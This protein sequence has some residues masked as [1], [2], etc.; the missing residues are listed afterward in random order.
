MFL[1]L[2]FVLILFN[3]L[4]ISF[5]LKLE[6]PE[7]DE[8]IDAIQTIIDQM[9]K[10]H[11]TINFISAFKDDEAGKFLD[12]KEELLI[13]CKLTHSI[14]LDNYTKIVNS[15]LRIKKNSIFLL[16]TIERFRILLKNIVPTKF[17]FNGNFLFVLIAG[18]M[19]EIQEIFAK[20]WL[21][22]IYNVNV[23]YAATNETVLVTFLP[24]E[25]SE[26]CGSTKPKAINIFRDGEFES[27]M[28]FPA[29]MNNFNGCPLRV[30]TFEDE[31]VVMRISDDEYRGYCIDLLM[32][33]AKQLNFRPDINFLTQE[34]AY[35]IVYD[36][37]TATG[38]LGEVFYNR[39][40]IALGDFFLK[41]NRIPKFD[42]T[43]AYQVM[44]LVWIIPPGLRYTPLQKLMLP[45]EFP[46]WIYLMIT[47]TIGIIV[48]IFINI[49]IPQMRAFVYGVNVKHPFLN[50]AVV[51]L[52]SQQHRMPKRN[53]ARFLI[54]NFMLFTLV[55]RSIYQGSLYRFLQS[56]GRQ[57][58][59]QS[60][61]EML[62]NDFTF[63]AFEASTLDLIKGSSL[64]IFNKTKVYKKENF[65]LHTELNGDEKIAGL[66]T[67]KNVVNANQGNTTI[68]YCKEPFM[69]IN[70]VLYLQKHSYIT[71]AFDE[72][73]KQL[74]AAGLMQQW[75]KVHHL[76]KYYKSVMNRKNSIQKKLSL[77]QLSGA[78]YLL[79]FGGFVGC[80][81]F[82]FELL[83][84]RYK[85]ITAKNKYKVK[86]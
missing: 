54:M 27:D 3:F 2:F 39:S 29:K 47:I 60:V 13:K 1:K 19:N 18:S 37:G 30:V 17:D 41:P 73:I 9:I 61:E 7:K 25:S 23:I 48:I 59:V 80:V 40:D 52:G 77:H 55:L 20:M 21:K 28:I 36:N 5:G 82:V 45:F 32:A 84:V 26:N 53:F 81:S 8:I 65:L 71:K 68:I 72:N 56:D 10:Q 35:G 42:F 15:P 74:I 49:K 66:E 50:M 51:I 34:L 12:F 67:I 83:C 44:N 76:E 6:S 78:F 69:Y 85:R 75:I 33:L 16:D 64:E 63:Y 58:E 11:A 70:I 22:N 43:M 4:R 46:V 86:I 57:K 79:L 31:D 24:F 62:A 38:A 14:R